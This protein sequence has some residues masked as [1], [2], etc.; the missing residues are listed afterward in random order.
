MKRISIFLLFV[1]SAGW[2]FAQSLTLDLQRTIAM[3]NDSSL[4]A[5]R[6]RNMYLAG[7]WEFRSY[8]ANRLPSL[9]LNITP[10]QYYRYITNRYDSGNDRDVYRMQ[11]MY[12]A[13]GGLEISQNVD[14]TGGTL[15]MESDLSYMRN[16]GE[17]K[18]T[19]YSSIPFRIGYQQQLLGY[20]PFRWDRKI[21]PVKYE[22]VKRQFIYNTEQVA[23][24]A[25]RYFFA[26]ALAQAEY[27][28]AVDNVASTDTI[29]KIGMQRHKIASISRADLLTLELDKEN[30][31]NTLENARISMKRCMSDLVAYLN[32]PKETYLE[33]LLPSQPSVLEISLDEAMEHARRNNPMYLEQRQ[34]VLEASRN[35]DK[36]RKESRFNASVNASVGFNQVAEKFK[37]VYR[38]PLQ[39]DLV[40]L[41]VSVPLIDWGVR[42]GKYNMAKNNLNVAQI[43]ARQEEIKVEEDVALTVSDFNIQQRLIGRTEKALDL[44]EMAYEQT[45]QRF[46]IGKTDVSSLTLAL[47][48]QQ[49]ARRN[50]IAALQSYW[51]NYYKLRR[52]TL[53][54]FECGFSLSDKFDFNAGMY[55]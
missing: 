36:T 48:R 43:T 8:K 3:A 9:T 46:I 39:Q 11:Q 18:Y 55:R 27:K 1:I 28:L 14:F 51:Q 15:Y 10:A 19:Q 25:V 32:L 20:N 29:Y 40:A 26:L 16:F 37:D 13:N 24:E 41:T 21:E 47:N 23:E 22:K 50:Y 30:A 6:N 38:H 54:D 52:L 12:S 42:K 33:L 53:H 4:T 31:L 45:R 7:Y 2:L 17:S 49:E 34:N 44:A 5:F 35:V